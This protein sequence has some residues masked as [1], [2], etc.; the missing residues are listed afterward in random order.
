MEV[1]KRLSSWRRGWIAD[2]L[3]W[4]GD[5]VSLPVPYYPL[6]QLMWLGTT[7]V[8]LDVV[9]DL[10]EAVLEREFP[11][12]EALLVI[13]SL[14]LHSDVQGLGLRKGVQLGFVAL[15]SELDEQPATPRPLLGKSEARELRD[16]RLRPWLEEKWELL[17]R[18]CREVLS[19]LQS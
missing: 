2:E 1:R 17:E 9:K 14:L 4:K 6:R 18:L 19:V 15:D 7:A 5:S 8:A 16:E 11:V 12:P 3:P 10:L 13:P